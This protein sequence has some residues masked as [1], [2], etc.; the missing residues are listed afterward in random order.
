M[1]NK[2]K[3]CFVIHNRANFARVKTV[4]ECI[5]SDS[6]A[7]IQIVLASSSLI[8]HY[9]RL[10]DI[11][12]TY[13]LEKVESVYNVIMGDNPV[14]MAKTTGL[15]LIELAQVFSRIK[16]DCVITVAD[17]HE[18]LATAI[19]ASYMNIPLIHIQGGEISGSIDESVRHACTKLAHLHFPSTEKA[20]KVVMQLGENPN[21]VFNFGCPA[22][23]IVHR[24]P[25]IK[26]SRIL[27]KYSGVGPEF[28]VD[29][30]FL[31]VV[32]HPVTTHYLTSS[33]EN[34]ML[35][36][37]IVEARKPAIWLWPNVDSGSEGIAKSLR[38]FRE[39]NRDVPIRF[40][41]NLSPE[42]YASLLRQAR[43]IVGNSSSGIRESSFLGLPAI[44]IGDRQSGRESGENV[45]SVDFKVDS[46]FEA[47]DFQ[48]SHGFYA[49]SSLY[50]LGDAGPK[51][52]S[53]I[54]S[55]EPVLEK[56]FFWN[57]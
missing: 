54:M 57:Q 2:R 15:A 45:I 48:W 36:K 24:S 9:G 22:I 14:S 33:L 11:I 53:K 7:E 41:T 4:L 39:S 51:I 26:A 16:P 23:D 30:G 34:E 37:A 8:K 46:I 43:C 49:G 50:G 44:N 18:T 56:K 38:R 20:K 29:D 10:D 40:Y 28:N 42:D 52:A 5:S 55:F 19:A 35:L 25:N 13:G 17:R 21:T 6:N 47:I 27:G 32:Q 12:E 3:V 31:L 1:K